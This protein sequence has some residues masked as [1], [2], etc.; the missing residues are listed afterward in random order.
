M[1][2]GDLVRVLPFTVGTHYNILFMTEMLDMIGK[3]YTIWNTYNDK[4]F[5]IGK[6]IGSTWRFPEEYLELVNL[7]ITKH[8]VGT[9]CE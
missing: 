5:S 2:K 6:H 3:T 7:K 1:L 9:R 4:T 8:R